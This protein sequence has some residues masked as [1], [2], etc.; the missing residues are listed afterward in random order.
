[1]EGTRQDILT[2]VKEWMADCDAPNILWLKGHPGVG[3]SAIAMSIVEHLR[4]LKRLGSSF[5]FQRQEATVTTPSAL[6]RSVAYNLARQH[7]GVRARIIA[8]LA[9]D[10][11]ITTTFNV[12]KLFQQLIFEPLTATDDIPDGRMPI[13]VIDALDECGGLGGQYSDAR[14]S[15]IKTLKRWASFSGKFKLL[16]TSRGESDIEQFFSTTNHYLHDIR[17]GHTVDHQSFEDVRKFLKHEFQ[18]IAAGYS[19]SLQSDWPGDQAIEKLTSR[20]AGLF[21]W[22]RTV[23]KFVTRGDPPEQL[24][25]VLEGGGTGDIDALYALI[26]NASFPEPTEKVIK[27]FR[28]V[29]GT[30]ILAKRPLPVGSVTQLL[31]VDPWTVEH[32]CKALHS[33]LGHGAVLSLIHQSFVDFVVDPRRCP[34]MFLISR[35]QE[36]RT[37]TLACL[38]TMTKELKFNICELET[39]CAANTEIGSLDKLVDLKIPDALQYSCMHWSS[40]LCLHSNAASAEVTALLDEFLT[41]PRPLYWIEVMSLMGKVPTAV[42]ALREI[43]GCTEVYMLSPK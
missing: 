2:V 39:S 17:T 15:L 10:E 4:D 23:V 27:T 13:F 30:I 31:A 29:I 8:A 6:W 43:K 35:D 3:K 19:S 5:F 26:L 40:H 33:V 1:M 42:S 7:P 38:Q 14:R 20:A 11:S 25:R 22:A 41:G 37:L 34:P 21:I 16:V 24:S 28:S 12:E 9:T 18:E 36:Q 32:I